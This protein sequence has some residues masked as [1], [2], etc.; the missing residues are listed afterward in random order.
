M[1]FNNTWHCIELNACNDC[2]IINNRFENFGS[3]GGNNTEVIQIDFAGTAGQYPFESVKLDN[4]H[5]SNINISNN[6]FRN[7]YTTTG[8]I[9]N[10]TYYSDG[11]YKYYKNITIYNTVFE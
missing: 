10:H 2:W 5:C 6:I 7:I 4:V 9:G 11:N 3:S 8:V 1:N